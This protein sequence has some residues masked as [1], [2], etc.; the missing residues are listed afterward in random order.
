MAVFVNDKFSPQAAS[1]ERKK[2]L[3][4]IRAENEAR[5][6]VS[7]IPGDE[8]KMLEINEAIHDLDARLTSLEIALKM[9]GTEK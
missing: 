9:D 4:E 3:G 2:D 5:K 1:N 6:C 7:A 8:V